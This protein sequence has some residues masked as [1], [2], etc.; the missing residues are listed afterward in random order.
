M[1][2]IYTLCCE[3][4]GLR[5]D[6]KVNRDQKIL[7]T[8]LILYD[9]G[10]LPVNVESEKLRIFSDR[11]EEWVDFGLSYRQAEIFNGDILYIR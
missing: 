1:A 3:N 6:I 11:N 2:M 10:V 4:K 5:L 8:M 7:E 9:G